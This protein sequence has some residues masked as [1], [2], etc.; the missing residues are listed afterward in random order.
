MLVLPLVTFQWY[1]VGC[2][3]SVGWVGYINIIRK[4]IGSEKCYWL[5]RIMPLYKC[6][7]PKYLTALLIKV[8]ICHLQM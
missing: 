3:E 1:F 7:V 8:F 6:F 5:H 2:I 4:L